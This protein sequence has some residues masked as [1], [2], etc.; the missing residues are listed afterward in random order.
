MAHSWCDIHGEVAIDIAMSHSRLSNAAR[1][2]TRNKIKKEALSGQTM[3]KE[4][5][6]KCQRRDRWNT[7]I[8]GVDGYIHITVSV[9]FLFFN[10]C[11]TI[12]LTILHYSLICVVHVASFSTLSRIL[13]RAREVGVSKKERRC[14]KRTKILLMTTSFFLTSQIHIFSPK[15]LSF[16]PTSIYSILSRSPLP[17]SSAQSI[18]SSHFWSSLV[19]SFPNLFSII[20]FSATL[21]SSD[22]A[23]I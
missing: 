18:I 13:L 21:L 4:L 15:V 9:G 7:P 23:V 11:L 10:L 22:P 20:L 17:R 2:I 19:S 12:R 16:C 5:D 3:G 1:K 6:I 14:L 8:L